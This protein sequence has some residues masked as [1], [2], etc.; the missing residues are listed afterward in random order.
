VGLDG[1]IDPA[2][3]AE[4]TVTVSPGE[5]FDTGVKAVS[6]TLYEYV[7]VAVG[8]VV[9]VEAVAEAIRVLHKPSEYHW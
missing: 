1:V 8:E 9:R 2:M 5:H 3:M 7:V 6:V 4:L